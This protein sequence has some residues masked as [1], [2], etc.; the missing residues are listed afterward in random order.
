ML[1]DFK[2]SEIEK[3]YKAGQKWMILGE[4]VYDVTNF[5]HPGGQDILKP[6]IGGTKDA[7]EAFESNDH[8]S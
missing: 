2:Y 7:L 1:R 8:S 4:K 5:N 6:F 3:N